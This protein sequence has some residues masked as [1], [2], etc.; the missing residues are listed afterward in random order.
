ML[1]F[2]VYPDDV[3]ATTLL[4]NIK[5]TSSDRRVVFNLCI[6]DII[7]S[8]N[9]DDNIN[10]NNNNNNINCTIITVYNKNKN[11]KKPPTAAALDR[12]KKIFNNIR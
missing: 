12:M 2:Y 8:N 1:Y 5:K 4:T 3:V 6:A 9:D 7:Y 10:M 11:N